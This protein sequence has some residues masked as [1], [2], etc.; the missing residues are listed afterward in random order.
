MSEHFISS[1]DD[2]VL[3]NLMRLIF[4]SEAV[5]G[6]AEVVSKISIFLDRFYKVLMALNHE[7]WFLVHA[8]KARR[9]KTEPLNQIHAGGLSSRNYFLHQ[10]TA[11]QLVDDTAKYADDGGPVFDDDLESDD[12]ELY[13]NEDQEKLEDLQLRWDEEEQ[14][15]FDELDNED[16]GD[17]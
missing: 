4:S 17:E 16:F 2:E 12:W 11:V 5:L 3:S 1:I 13:L 14:R 7:E 9:E 6:G 15:R 10:I 8:D